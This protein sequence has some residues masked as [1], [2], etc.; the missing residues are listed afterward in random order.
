MRPRL[1]LLL[2]LVALLVGGLAHEAFA[3]RDAK[4]RAAKRPLTAAQ[5]AARAKLVATADFLEKH[6]LSCGCQHHFPAAKP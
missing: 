3:G 1:F 4:P 5:K 6:K 2:A